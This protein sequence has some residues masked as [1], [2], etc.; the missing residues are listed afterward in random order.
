MPAANLCRETITNRN[1]VD[2]LYDI[3]ESSTDRNVPTLGN[4]VIEEIPK[5]R[6]CV[7]SSFVSP[8]TDYVMNEAAYKNICHLDGV[9]LL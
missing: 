1:G 9:S 6:E 7:L 5:E 2:S 4:V 8:L 3:S